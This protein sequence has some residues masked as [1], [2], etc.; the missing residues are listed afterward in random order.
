ML[1]WYRYSHG[2]YGIVI[3]YALI[4]SIAPVCGDNVAIYEGVYL[5][6]PQH[7]SI[8]NNVSIQPMAYIECG[9]KDIGIEIG[10]DVSIAHDVTIMATSHNYDDVNI[11]I[12]DQGVTSSKTIIEKM[13]GLVLRQLFFRVYGSL[14]DV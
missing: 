8:G 5:L 12:K 4:K 10:D 2:V 11:P 6:H 9:T 14:P 3:R 1:E 7:M 13:F